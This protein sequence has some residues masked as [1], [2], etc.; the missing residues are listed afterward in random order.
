MIE[1]GMD[2]RARLVKI[3]LWLDGLRKRGWEGAFDASAGL[4]L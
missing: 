3:R 2:A 4:I 1:F